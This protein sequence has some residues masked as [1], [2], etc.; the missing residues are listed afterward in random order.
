VTDDAKLSTYRAKRNFGKTAEP[1]GDDSVQ[2]SDR[3]RFVI[4]KHDATRLHYDL[5]LEL[6]GV[7]KSWAV[8]KGASLDP[9]DKRLAVEVEDHPLDY[10]DFEGTIPKGQYGGG[11]VQLWDRGYWEPDG[12]KDPEKA[13]ADGDFKFRLHGER[14]HGGFVLVRMKHD[15]NGGKRTNWLLIKHRDE[16]AVDGKGDAI[17]AEDRSI[18]S[19]RTMAQIAA[20]E[21]AA[22]KPFMRL[23]EATGAD[24][25]WDSKTGLV[26]GGAGSGKAAGGKSG[27]AKSGKAKAPRARTSPKAAGGK[28]QPAS[29]PEFI[30]PQLCTSVDRPPA[31]AG[32]GHEIKFDGYRVQLRAAGGEVTVKTRKG[33]DWTAKFD[34]IAKAGQ[35]LPDGI[36][37]GEI[38]ALDQSGAPDF[39]AL[40]A[41]L[42]EGRTEDLVFF[43]FDLL[44]DGE[45]D[46]RRLPL[47]E[48]KERLQKR[49]PEGPDGLIRFVEH[50]ETGGDAVLRSACRLSLEGIVSKKLD[51]PYASGRSSNWTKAKCRAGH[52]V[53]IGGWST[54]AGRFRSLLVGVH[55]G[56][57]FV[58]LGRVGTGYGE[59]K[60]RALL[61]RLKEVAA[62]KS[63]FTGIGAPR[64]EPGVTW[65][66][67]E[68]VAEIEFAGWTG[69]GMVRQASFKGLREDKPAEEV[70]VDKPAKASKTPTP[71]P[72]A[73]K[74]KPLRRSS[75]RQEVMGV[76]LSNP[77]KALWPD[78]DDGV[79]VTKL[80]LARYFEQVGGWMIEHIRGRPCSIIR[81]PNGMGGEQFFQ[82]HAMPGS[83][84][85]LELVTVFGDRK[86]YLQID[87]IEGLAAVAQIAALELHPWNCQPGKPEEPGRLVFDLDPGPDVPFSAVVEAAREMRDRL[88]A[89]GLVSFCK[90]TGGKGLHVVTPLARSKKPTPWPEA[91][92]FAHEVC[93][94]MSR[95]QPD[96][97]LD[98]MAKKLREGRIFLDYLRNDRM[99]TAVAPLSPRAR[100]GA[101]VSMPLTWSQVKAD[102]DPRRYTLRTVPELLRKTKA[103][104]DYCDGERPLEDA[105]ARLGKAKA[106]A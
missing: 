80:D 101:T 97:Y 15:R 43:A 14:L 72:K 38:V 33:L 26:L 6:D 100:P 63:P 64:R 102:L 20:G 65:T 106:A 17:L 34:A 84:N 19:G 25:V 1:S 85:L 66:R 73:A 28:A 9:H 40:Q 60:V 47:S 39:A 71:E 94:R 32:W 90:T 79:P 76:L 5:R 104:A 27:K 22:P 96:R 4:Q 99:A 11:T 51:A 68:L 77:D 105:I 92:E 36:Y 70:E 82:R 61:P 30:P 98:K 83:S 29:M 7:F 42:S 46:L 23:S 69:D 62:E 8:T 18:A 50:F 10:G 24:A 86:P 81:A 103:W 13:L 93:R 74:A 12:G 78:A 37:D 53:V 54:T 48:R 2:G 45:E 88:D 95:D 21:G 56:E 89:L 52:E 35:T 3:R 44:F 41:A 58:Y 57:H 67:P 75:A 31:Q 59:A 91:K 16:H 87:R 49:L 55:R